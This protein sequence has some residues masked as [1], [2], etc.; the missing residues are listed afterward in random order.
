MIDKTELPSEL[1]S[2]PVI[3]CDFRSIREVIQMCE[4]T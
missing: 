4:N 3:T 2:I 1:P